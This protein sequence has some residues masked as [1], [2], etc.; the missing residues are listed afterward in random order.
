[1]NLKFF[2]IKKSAAIAPPAAIILIWATELAMTP[3][4]WQEIAVTS[5]ISPTSLAS[6]LGIRKEQSSKCENESK[7][8]KIWISPYRRFPEAGD[9][10]KH[11]SRGLGDYEYLS[12]LSGDPC[13]KIKANYGAYKNSPAD[14]V[15]EKARSQGTAAEILSAK[16]L[17]FD[18][19]ALDLN[20]AWITSDE[21][22]QSCQL[23]SICRITS[24]NFAIFSLKSDMAGSKAIKAMRHV[25]AKPSGAPIEYVKNLM[26]FRSNEWWPIETSL[27][28]ENLWSWSKGLRLDRSVSLAGENLGAIPIN[29]E[30]ILRP[31]PAIAKLDLV[32]KCKNGQESKRLTAST[33]VPISTTLRDCQPTSIEVESFTTRASIT[34]RLSSDQIPPLGRNDSRH[35][36]FAIEAKQLELSDLATWR[37]ITR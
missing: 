32:M 15:F 10:G 21:L 35:S 4:I 13:K 18:T 17:G 1:M 26:G 37:P 3:K 5:T 12:I 29:L 28:G 11:A 27:D 9:P 34:S 25:H 16:S 30:I 6:S 36:L 8:L 22:K 31:A 33:T 19:F 23:Y 24:D 2:N 20:K 7:H 14:I